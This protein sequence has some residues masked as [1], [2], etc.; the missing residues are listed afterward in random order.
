[1]SNTRTIIFVSLASEFYSHRFLV[2]DKNFQRRYARHRLNNSVAVE[3]KYTILVSTVTTVIVLYPPLTDQLQQQVTHLR[4]DNDPTKGW[5]VGR[6][7][8]AEATAERH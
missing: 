5:S 3:T 7:P 2:G 4:A 1:M 8:E 6:I